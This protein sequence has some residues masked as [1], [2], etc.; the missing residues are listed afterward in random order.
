MTAPFI[1]YNCQYFFFHSLTSLFVYR[2]LGTKWTICLSLI[3]YMPFIACQMYPSFYTLVPA[4]LLLGL[5]AGPLWCAKC[6]YLSLVM[7]H[8]VFLFFQEN[9]RKLLTKF[10]HENGITTVVKCKIFMIELANE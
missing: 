10:S 7:L 2:W 6:T 8:Y 5:G 3:T 1:F 9:L 4:G